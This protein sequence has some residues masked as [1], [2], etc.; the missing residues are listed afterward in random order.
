MKRKIISVLLAAAMLSSL[1]AGCGG[2]G[3][4]GKSEA[5]MLSPETTSVT[6]SDGITVEV[7]DY[8]LDGETELT[9][10]KQPAEE[11]KEEGYKI[12]A[13]DFTLGE[14]HELDDFITIR[15]PYDTT[16]CDEGQD[17]ARCV[18]AKYKNESTGVWEDVLFEVDAEAGELVI[19][20]DHLSY[21][22]AFYIKNEGKRS[23]SL[24]RL[25]AGGRQGT[26]SSPIQ[27]LL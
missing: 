7:G 13:Y 27:L 11:N 18:G 23:A 26:L 4:G 9:V 5:L 14:L 25:F 24:L 19:Y 2:P 17:P 21:Y 8:V 15:I 10:T 16:Y 3:G 12:E 22:G 6:T 1:L 20:T